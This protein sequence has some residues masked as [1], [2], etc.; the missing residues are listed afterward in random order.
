M[1]NLLPTVK[2][3]QARVFPTSRVSPW[4]LSFHVPSPVPTLVPASLLCPSHGGLEVGLDLLYPSFSY[5]AVEFTR[6]LGE[7]QSMSASAVSSWGRICGYFD[8]LNELR[9]MW[10]E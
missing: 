6:G 5:W 10:N 1:G 2:G 9:D 3:V 7:H 4:V 8:I